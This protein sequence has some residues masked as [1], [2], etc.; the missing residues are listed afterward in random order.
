LRQ[1]IQGR[2]QIHQVYNFRYLRDGLGKWGANLARRA[3]RGF[4]V[5]SSSATAP[6][7]SSVL[8]LGIGLLGLLA[9]ARSRRHAPPASR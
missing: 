7:P 3:F 2:V 6:E 9:M 5:G 8:L 4:S 1:R